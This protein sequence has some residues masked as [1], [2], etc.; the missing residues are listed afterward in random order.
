MYFRPD[1]I[2]Q[3]LRAKIFPLK[4]KRERAPEVVSSI[5]LPARR[6]ERSIS[7]LVVSTPRVSAQTGTTGKRTKAGRGNSSFT[8]RTVKKEEEFGDDHTESASSPET[9]KKFTQNKRQVKKVIPLFSFVFL[10][11]CYTM[12]SS[13]Y[14]FSASESLPL[15]KCH[16]KDTVTGIML[17]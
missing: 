5:T 11:F 1:H 2:L 6:K 10:L 3:D 7:S 15:R 13:L 16:E 4:R 17:N 8:K 9:L 14:I 12:E